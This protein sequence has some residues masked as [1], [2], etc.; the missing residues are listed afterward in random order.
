[1]KINT[2]INSL[3]N[4][5]TIKQRNKTEKSSETV[6]AAKPVNKNISPALSSLKEAMGMLKD[7]Q[8]LLLSSVPVADSVFNNIDG[9]RVDKL[10]S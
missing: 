4:K 5:N 10:L 7:T 9:S 3:L 1:M 8:A 6:K 2:G